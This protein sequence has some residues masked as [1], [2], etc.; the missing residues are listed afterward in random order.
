MRRIAAMLALAL[1]LLGCDATVR[2]RTSDTDT[3]LGCFLMGTFGKL[4]VDAKYGTALHGPD[5]IR[6]VV[7][8]RGFT[9]RRVGSEVEVL[10]RGGRLVATTGKAYEIMYNTGPPGRNPGEL[11]A[12]GEVHLVT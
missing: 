6:P 8:P 11:Y 5:A 9:G 12:C 10:D 3:P 1:Y 4:I 2:L 7:W